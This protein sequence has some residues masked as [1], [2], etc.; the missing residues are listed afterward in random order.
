MAST[1][2]KYNPTTCRFEPARISIVQVLSYGFSLMVMSA[3]LFAGIAYVQGHFF[4]TQT[5]LDLRAEN[6]ALQKHYALLSS[7]IDKLDGSL[8]AIHATEKLVGSKL[9]NEQD[10]APAPSVIISTIPEG[11]RDARELLNTLK[12]KVNAS[13]RQATNHNY[14]YSTTL[15]LTAQDKSVVARWPSGQPVAKKYLDV[16]SGFGMRINPFHKGVYKHEGL[17][18]AAPQGTSVFATGSGKVIDT[19]SSNLQVGYGSYI[20]IEHPNGI[21]TR[22]AHLQNIAVK[23]GQ[24]VEKGTLIGT[25]GM[26]GGAVAPHL[27]YEIIKDGESVN[28]MLYM[29][30]G[31]TGLEFTRL[32]SQSE[33][34][35]QSLD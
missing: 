4:V 22:Y 7:Q 11:A 29:V 10:T 25:V 23:K 13:I 20:E 27:H 34:R 17:D 9:F 32:K 19:G 5:T 30:Q 1:R 16:A 2:F 18:F 26:S 33:K 24:A 31:L 8:T 35:N 28:P 3:L 15:N 6:Y 14:R 21:V 12:S